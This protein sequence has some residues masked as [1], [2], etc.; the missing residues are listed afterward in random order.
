MKSFKTISIIVLALITLSSCKKYLDVN[1]TKGKVIPN[2]VEQF[3]GLLNYLY[4][5]D[6]TES[7]TVMMTDDV[8]LD[9]QNITK[10][11][12]LDLGA[13]QFRKNSNWAS[14]VWLKG[15]NRIN[16]FNTIIDNVMD[17]ERGSKEDK[18]QVKAI[19]HVL[20][21][22]EYYSLVNVFSSVY[23]KGT[24]NDQPGVPLILHADINQRVGKREAVQKVYQQIM[25]D[26]LNH[27]DK[28]PV[29]TSTLYEINQQG[30]LGML[31]RIYLQM[32]DYTKAKEMAERALAISINV[33]D[34]NS[35]L[36]SIPGDY[37]GG[38]SN[39][40]DW[41]SWPEGIYLRKYSTPFKLG[42]ANYYMSVELD[43]LYKIGDLRRTIHFHNKNKTGQTYPT[44]WYLAPNT[45]NAGFRNIGISTPEL[46]LIIAESAARSGASTDLQVALTQ[47]NNL[48]KLRFTPDTY[49]SLVSSNASVVFSWVMDERRR[50]LF[51]TPTRFF[52]LKRLNLDA[53]SRKNIVHTLGT[54]TYTLEYNSPLYQPLIPSEAFYNSDITQNPQ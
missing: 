35:I 5:S 27:I 2:D 37:Y 15:Y 21:G 28:L 10:Y 17:L 14:S 48:R 22:F 19:A 42:A 20:R 7:T 30:A 38:F 47:L 51:F 16:I 54:A 29:T 11:D 40:P 23:V 39:F 18:E 46:Q 34:Y 24:A 45:S 52:D 3:K 50:E 36:F 25:D 13:Y 53:A 33:L 44:G 43:D 26:I 6:Y 9:P 31:A 32:Q 12:Q 4:N 49:T 1:P 41:A 8:T